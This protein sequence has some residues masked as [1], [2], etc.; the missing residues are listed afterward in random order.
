[1]VN[2]F[3]LP[4]EFTLINFQTLF[5][6]YDILKM[7]FNT[8]LVTAIS[9]FLAATANTLAGF[10]F[11][12]RPYRGSDKIL[13]SIVATM[14]VPGIVLVIP[15]YLMMSKLHLINTYPSIILK[16]TAM[17]IP[18]SLYLITA[19]FKLIPTELL[20]SAMMDG[21]GLFKQYY[22]IA[23]RL[24]KP[25][26]LT[27]MAL[28]F[29]SFWNE[30]LYALL[31]LQTNSK[32]TLTVGVATTIDQYTTNMPVLMT[33]LLINCVPVIVFFILANRY[34][35]KGLTAGAFK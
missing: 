19:N 15:T 35:V 11:A 2:L 1:M 32:R 13:S 6:R 23:L 5:E 33:G 24:G 20:E 16:Y 28:N 18:F 8:T 21:A 7:T 25:A 22:Y 27:M 3:G 10:I 12:K 4:K 29:L 31:F 9:V 17:S 30:L 14:A 26:I 34:L